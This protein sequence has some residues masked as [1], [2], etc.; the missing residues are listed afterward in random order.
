[1]D[2]EVARECAKIIAATVYNS[3]TF[4][5]E[6]SEFNSL[7]NPEQHSISNGNKINRVSSTFEEVCGHKKSFFS[8]TANIHRPPSLSV[9][10]AVRKRSRI[11]FGANQSL[12][13]PLSYQT[14]PFINAESETNV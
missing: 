4:E 14:I 13:S 12:A 6:M 1:L 10:D 5:R 7:N 11:T 9:I 3:H 8:S 2:D